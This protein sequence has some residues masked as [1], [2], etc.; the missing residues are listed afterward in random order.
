[1]HIT[2]YSSSTSSLCCSLCGFK[3]DSLCLASNIRFLFRVREL[4]LCVFCTPGELA[5][6]LGA[7]MKPYVALIMV[8]ASPTND[9]LLRLLSNYQTDSC[10]SI[11]GSPIECPDICVL[12]TIPSFVVERFPDVQYFSSE[13]IDRH[14]YH[15]TRITQVLLAD[16]IDWVLAVLFDGLV[17]SFWLCPYCCRCVCVCVRYPGLVCFIT[18]L[19]PL[20]DWPSRALVPSSSSLVPLPRPT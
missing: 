7:N 2:T 3:S 1:M 8:S 4:S 10:R 16:Q 9:F 11:F 6:K 5:L 18:L 13:Q 20:V 14:H 17:T 15:A 12:L 19:L